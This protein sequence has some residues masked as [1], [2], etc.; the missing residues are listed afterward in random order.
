MSK[1]LIHHSTVIQS[2]NR[3]KTPKV[4]VVSLV[5]SQSIL[6]FLSAF[7][8]SELG[9]KEKMSTDM[10]LRDRNSGRE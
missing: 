5:L 1:F 9:G 3:D 10:D 2:S 4:P 7:H 6:G 8:L